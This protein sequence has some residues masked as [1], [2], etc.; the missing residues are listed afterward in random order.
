MASEETISK[1]RG[2]ALGLPVRPL[3]C[4]IIAFTMLVS[5]GLC[6]CTV[7]IDS[8]GIEA[9]LSNAVQGSGKLKEE[10]RKL[11]DFKVIE[12]TGSANVTVRVGESPAATISID[13]N[14]L[15][16]IKTKVNGDTLQINTEKPYNSAQKSKITVTV[17]LLTTFILSG[18]GNVDIENVKGEKFKS[19]ISGSGNMTVK[20]SANSELVSIE[21]AGSVNARELKAQDVTVSISGSGSSEVSAEKTLDV[22]ITGS[23]NV[24]YFGKPKVTQHITGSG[25]ITAP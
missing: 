15:P 6:G 10:T 24:A 9:G 16:L 7:K 11:P 22:D 18:A 25:S 13:D 1:G 3:V 23:G 2:R 20:G 5:T 19:S 12:L 14:L 8:S 4:T 17:P 21:G